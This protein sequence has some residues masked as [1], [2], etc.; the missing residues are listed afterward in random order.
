MWASGTR[1]ASRRRCSPPPAPCG[2]QGKHPAVHAVAAAA[3]R[4]AGAGTLHGAGPERDPRGAARPTARATSRAPTAAAASTSTSASS[5]GCSAAAWPTSR[6]AWKA[7][8]DGAATGFRLLGAL[9]LLHLTWHS[10]LAPP[11]N[12]AMGLARHSPSCLL[13]TAD[14]RRAAADARP[15]VGGDP[16]PVLFRPRRGGGLGRTSGTPSGWQRRPVRR[17]HPAAWAGSPAPRRRR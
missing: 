8:H 9:L 11:A 12:G 13:R 15:A 16:G 1:L 14:D 7:A 10:A 6:G 17:T 4:H 2:G 5:R 3:S